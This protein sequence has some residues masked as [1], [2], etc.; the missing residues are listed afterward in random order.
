MNVFKLIFHPEAEQ[1]TAVMH[2]VF[3]DQNVSVN[4]KTFAMQ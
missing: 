1:F 3:I 4:V 2:N